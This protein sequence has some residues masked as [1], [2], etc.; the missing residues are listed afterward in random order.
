MM[1]QP[2]THF[3]TNGTTVVLDTGSYEPKL[4]EDVF[5]PRD[6][7]VSSPAYHTLAPNPRKHMNSHFHLSRWL[8]R[9][10]CQCAYRLARPACFWQLV[11][12]ATLIATVALPTPAAVI[13]AWVQRYNGPG[14]GDDHPWAVAVDASGNVVAT[15]TSESSY[16]TAKYAA[17]NGGLL[18][19][20]RLPGGEA[21]AVAGGG[22]AIRNGG[23]NRGVAGGGGGLVS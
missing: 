4:A 3:G 15:G 14:N 10:I 19:E 21:N 9:S 20:K 2:L 16:Y 6:R 5:L 11:S 8:V 17:A 12:F 22:D 23:G 1:S 13:E 7:S 18:W